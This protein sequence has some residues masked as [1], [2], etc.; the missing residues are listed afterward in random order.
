[1]QPEKVGLIILGASGF[2]AG[3]LLRLLSQHQQAEVLS[4]VSSSQAG[5]KLAKLHPQ[6]SAF[7]DLSCADKID[8]KLLEKYSKRCLISTLPNEISS[9]TL[10]PLLSSCHAQNIKIIDLSG[11]F[12]LADSALHEQFYAQAAQLPEA[13]AG[14]VY[15]LPELFSE[16]ISG[17]DK[18][19]NPGCLATASILALAPLQPG[20]ISFAALCAAT[21]SSGAGRE[22]K[23][24]TQHALRHGNYCSYKVLKHQH[25]PEIS[26]ALKMLHGNAPEI[27]FVPHSLPLSR[28]IY[29]TAQMRLKQ[30][31]T[32]EQARE[33]YRLFYKNCPFVRIQDEESAQLNSVIGTNFCEIAIAARNN[34]L[35]VSAALDNLVKGMAGQAVQNLNL[36]FGLPQTNALW[37]PGLKLI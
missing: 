8:L 32:A 12:R 13:R 26:Q 3:E 24:S 15:G 17:A 9:Q 1:M 36:M 6:L 28:G 21:G 14:W 22:L 5:E 19:A 29:V 20:N 23:A 16:Q 25:E 2:G 30:N 35:A 10:A 37:F 7:Y 18:I 33:L 4:L 34:T 11:D 27:S 31:I